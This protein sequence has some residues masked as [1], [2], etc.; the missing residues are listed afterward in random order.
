MI[1]RPPRSTHCI[2]SAA[3]DVYKRQ[4]QSTWAVPFRDD[5]ELHGVDRVAGKHPPLG[6]NGQIVQGLVSLAQIAVVTIGMAL[7][8]FSQIDPVHLRVVETVPGYYDLTQ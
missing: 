3:S 8:E 4:T 5:V 1:R 6:L 7:D 2:S